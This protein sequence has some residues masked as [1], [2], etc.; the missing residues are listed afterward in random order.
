MFAGLLQK[1]KQ[2]DQVSSLDG[3]KPSE[4]LQIISDIAHGA[5]T[6]RYQILNDE[7]LPQLAKHEI[8]YLRRDE[9]NAKQRAWL[10]TILSAKSSQ[11]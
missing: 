8:R 6:Q 3:P 4:I 11:Y 10:K 2:G 9:L 7:I 5:V 1:M